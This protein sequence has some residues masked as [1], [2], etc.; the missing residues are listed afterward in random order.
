MRRTEGNSL[1]NPPS[2][3]A[4][5]PCPSTPEVKNASSVEVQEHEEK[6]ER[7][8]EKNS[9]IEGTPEGIKSVINFLKEKIPGLNVKHMNIHVEEESA[10]DKDSSKQL[11]EEKSNETIGGFVHNTE[12]TAPMDEFTRLPAK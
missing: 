2:I 11:M 9:N 10:E 8:V 5:S 4:K 3:P 7:Y 6:A 12:D 1:S